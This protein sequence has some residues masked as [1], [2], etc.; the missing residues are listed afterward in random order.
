MIKTRILCKVCVPHG[1]RLRLVQSVHF[2]YNCSA[3]VMDAPVKKCFYCILYF[4]H[5]LIKLENTN[6]DYS[7]LNKTNKYCTFAMHTISEIDN[8]T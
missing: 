6:V 4:L 7:V 2:V 8:R 5:R 1:T 3:G